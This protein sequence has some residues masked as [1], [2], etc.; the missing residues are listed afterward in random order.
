LGAASS[1][2]SVSSAVD[3]AT[4]S[5]TRVVDA[6]GFLAASSRSA[7]ERLSAKVEKASGVK[8]FVLVPPQTIV[9]KRKEFA[10]WLKEEKKRLGMDSSSMV[11]SVGPDASGLPQ[12]LIGIQR[13]TK[14][15]ERFQFRLTSAHFASTENAFGSEDYVSKNG[16]DKAVTNTAENEAACF[17]LAKDP[18]NREC[19]I[20]TL[21]ESRVKEV[22]DR[23]LGIIT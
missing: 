10:T 1:F 15:I 9:R 4:P 8:I 6:Q 18:S 14:V 2:P 21:A 19:G 17:I 13:G 23:E 20:F 12:G 16:Y 7:L 5:E 22:L 3:A 11:I